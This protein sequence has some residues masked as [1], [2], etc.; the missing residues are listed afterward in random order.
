MGGG[1]RRRVDGDR[2]TPLP[3]TRELERNGQLSSP[4]KYGPPY[5]GTGQ[6]NSGGSRRA[7]KKECICFHTY[8]LSHLFKSDK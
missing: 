7:T 6:G 3:G 4:A 8:F 5:V 2:E 1:T